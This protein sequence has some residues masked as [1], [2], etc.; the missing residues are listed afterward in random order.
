MR[1]PGSF[2]TK[3]HGGAYQQSGL[4]DLIGCVEGVFFGIEVKMPGK[5]DTLTKLQNHTLEQII[6][7]GG[8]ALVATDPKK[9]ADTVGRMLG[10]E[11]A[12]YENR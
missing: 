2:W 1:F 8:L 4:P 10:Y 6:E 12:H 3:I 5:E 9:T 11:E 7:A